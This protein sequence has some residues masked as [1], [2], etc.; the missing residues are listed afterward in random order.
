M[1][2]LREVLQYGL[3]G[4]ELEQA[5]VA[6]TGSTELEGFLLEEGKLKPVEGAEKHSATFTFTMEL[7]D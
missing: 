2:L 7:L 3:E 5:G 6:V 1:A 4:F